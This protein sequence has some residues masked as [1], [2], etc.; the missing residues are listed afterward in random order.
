[1]KTPNLFVRSKRMSYHKVLNPNKA[2]SVLDS[3]SSYV[4]SKINKEV[5]EERT[6]S[7]NVRG[8]LK[9][10][11]SVGYFGALVFSLFK[12]LA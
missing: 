1:L 3:Y 11:L 5:L 10:V 9:F 4:G 8:L 6:E 7:K 12:L 2:Y